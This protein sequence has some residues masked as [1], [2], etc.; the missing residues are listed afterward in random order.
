MLIIYHTQELATPIFQELLSAFIVLTMIAGT[1][2]YALYAYVEDVAKDVA[3]DEKKK[4]Y[5]RYN[6]VIDSLSGLKKEI[7]VNAFVVVGL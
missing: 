3:A 7:P 5:A 1:L 6:A 4:S 2:S